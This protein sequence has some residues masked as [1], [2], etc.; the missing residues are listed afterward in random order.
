MTGEG[1]NRDL[2]RIL[3]PFW[4]LE[5]GIDVLQFSKWLAIIK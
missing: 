3:R 5:G 1:K 4:M 2:D